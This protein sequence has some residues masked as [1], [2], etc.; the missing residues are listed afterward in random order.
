MF[1]TLFWNLV[2]KMKKRSF[3]LLEVL[4]AFSIFVIIMGMVLFTVTGSFRSLRQAEV[5]LLKEQK[6][7]LCLLG[8]SKE[9]SSMTRIVFPQMRFKG[10][11]QSFFL[12]MRRKIAL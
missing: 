4:I 11:S 9:I 2:L 1:V 6:Q 10:T 3:T 5:I 12:S 7:R 8:L